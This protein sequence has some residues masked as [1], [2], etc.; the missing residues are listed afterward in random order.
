MEVLTYNRIE[1][2][3]EINDRSYSF[4]VPYGVQ[5]EEAIEASNNFL[6]ALEKLEKEK[7]EEEKN[8]KKK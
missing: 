2:K 1:F 5:I 8:N 6:L 7:K 3:L 4:I